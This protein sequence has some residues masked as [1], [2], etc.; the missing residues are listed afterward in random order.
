MTT[1]LA[2]D[3]HALS[4]SI[5]AISSKSDVHRLLIC[6]SL[7]DT[8]SYIRFHA[9]LS[10]D[11]CATVD[12]LRAM[13]ADIVIEENEAL[14]GRITVRRP[15]R[16]HS[17]ACVLDCRES[18]STARFLLPL[19]SLFATGSVMTGRGRL[20]ER[21]FDEQCRALEA[22]GATFSSHTL[23]LRFEK[24]PL[25]QGEF[26]LRGDISSQ[27]ITG[28]LFLLPL[29]EGTGIQLTSPLESAGYVRLT[30]DAMRRFGVTVEQEKDRLW[31]T[32]TYHAPDSEIWAE[33]DWS[34]AA[35]WLAAA[36]PL[37][38]ITLTGLDMHSSQPDRAVV[39]FLRAMGMELKESEN[40][41]TASVQN[42]TKG[43]SFDA[44][45]CPDLVPMLSVR[46]SVSQGETII[47]GTRRLRIKESDRVDAICR[48]IS[49]LGGSIRADKDHIYIV[50]KPSLS[51][52]V[53]DSMGDH[54]IAMAASIAS[55]FCTAPVILHGAEAVSKS[56]PQFF[57]HFE[58]LKQSTGG[59]V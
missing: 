58:Q 34:N 7:C 17:Q 5:E 23:P 44:S 9:A 41:L 20:P 59:T 19:A 2:L 16:R 1:P 12:V 47:S 43:I 18:G 4:G 6:A 40:G 14:G 46:A 29:C 11:M 3:P 35:F 51:G 31:T 10:V 15:I 26:A 25:P 24:A 50:G 32:G 30:A 27:Y 37:H 55:V 13:G 42:A 56:Y 52:G 28:L 48:M 53:V 36:T 22:M 21:P 8:P 49:A 54:R 57:E 33:G 38:P 39:S 45:G